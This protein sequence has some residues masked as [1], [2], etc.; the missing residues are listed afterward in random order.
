MKC[1]QIGCFFIIFTC[2]L[3]AQNKYNTNDGAL[4]HGYDLVSYF[5]KKPSKGLD[6]FTLNYDGILLKFST[7]KNLVLFKTTPQKY[8]PQ[9]GGW[10]AYALGKTN[11][12][13]DINPKTYSIKNGKL[14]LFYNAYFTNTLKLWKKEGAERLITAGDRNW[15]QGI[16]MD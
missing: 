7:Q 11:E 4:A 5:S 8:L 16:L 3:N 2:S 1:F 6:S 13:V 10:C 14:Y 9:Y 12:K 15:Q